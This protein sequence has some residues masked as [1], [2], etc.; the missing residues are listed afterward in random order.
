MSHVVHPPESVYNLIPREEVQTQ[1]TSRY[2]SKYRPI[3]VHERKSV[4][5]DMR[6]MGPAKVEVPSPDKYLK[7]HSKEPKLPEKTECTKKARSAGT[8]RKPPVPARTDNP[9]MGIHTKRDFIKTATGFANEAPAYLRGHQQGTQAATREFRTCPKVHQEKVNILSKVC[10]FYSQHYGEVPDYLQ[11]RNEEERQAQEE[12]DNF[13]REQRERGAMNHLSDEKRQV[14]LQTLKKNWDQL[15]R[16]YQGLSF[17]MD[18]M[19][20]R[21]HKDR[22]EV[23]M[24]KLENDIKL[25][26][27]FKTIYIS[28]N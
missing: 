20:K 16:E 1:K 5:D 22:L 27:R 28:N 3:V 10:C 18:N 17:V 6:T 11:Q 15:H 8:V 4:K 23:A 9:P 19:S 25:F 12:Y 21:S 26:E 14:I 7:K 13:V 24:K 2:V